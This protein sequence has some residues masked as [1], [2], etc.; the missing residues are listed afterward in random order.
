MLGHSI[1]GMLL[2]KLNLEKKLGNPER[3]R[4]AN[5]LIRDPG[6]DSKI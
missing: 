2:F 4:V 5:L 1:V 3:D 6:F